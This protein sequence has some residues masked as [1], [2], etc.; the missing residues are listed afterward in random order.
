MNLCKNSFFDF[1]SISWGVLTDLLMSCV[2]VEYDRW[3]FGN[4]DPFFGQHFNFK[5]DLRKNWMTNEMAAVNCKNL[6]ETEFQPI[7][8]SLD[9][10]EGIS[11]D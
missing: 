8:I 11:D 1:V 9:I 2:N 10:N 4:V 5:L 3:V 6:D 7:K